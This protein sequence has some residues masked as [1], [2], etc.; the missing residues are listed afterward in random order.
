MIRLFEKASIEYSQER[1][2]EL[3]TFVVSGGGYI[4]VQLIAAMRDFIFRDLIKYYPTVDPNNIK[5]ILVEIDPK[6]IPKLH[7]KLG[8]YTMKH[9]RNTGINIRLK[10]RVTAV[11]P[12]HVVINGIDNVPTNTLIW[13]AG[14]LSN[15]QVAQMNTKKDNI[16]RVFVNEYL[17]IPD[18]PNVYAIG[19]C[20][21]FPDV[22]GQPIPPKAHTATRQAKVVAHNIISTI[23]GR[24][25]RPYVYSNPFEVIP[26]GPTNG[27]FSFHS[28]RLYGP[29]ARLL[30]MAGY[31][32]LVP[33]LYNRV[34]ISMD[35]LL[36]MIFGRDINLLK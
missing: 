12:D 1:Q 26:L 15:T 21:H 23:K 24:K 19:D 34:K 4:G 28:L 31:A 22:S 8:A 32:T 5:L 2:K 36:S 3:L 17:Q 27:I 29:I 18:F 35:W 11:Y 33:H 25:L 6:I 20:A 30:W 16:G 10:S 7:T 13:V 14:V 9:L